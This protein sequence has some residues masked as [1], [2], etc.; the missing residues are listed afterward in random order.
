MHNLVKQKICLYIFMVLMLIFIDCVISSVVFNKFFVTY[1]LLEI[2]VIMIIAAPLFLFKNNKFSIAYSSVI[3]GL[4]IV[5]MVI[6]LLLNYAS[7]DIFSIKYLFLFNE[8]AQVM[9][10]Q[11]VNAWYIILAIILVVIY[12]LF[13]V[14]IHRIF[15]HHILQNKQ[16]SYKYYP[17]ALSIMVMAIA[18][19]AIFRAIGSSQVKKDFKDYDVYKGM[20][21]NEIIENS[22]VILK[23]GAIKNYGMLTY[24]FG[25]I[26]YTIPQGSDSKD[27]N[28]FFNEGKIVNKDITDDLSGVCSDKNVITIMIE[29][30]VDY[31]I[32][33]TLTPNLYRLKNDGVDFSKNYSKNKTNMSEMIGIIGSIAEV[34]TTKNYNTKATLPN[35]LKEEGYQTSYFHNNSGSFYDR[36]KVLETTGFENLYFKEDIDPKQT[37]NFISANYPLDSYF[38]SGLSASGM[39]RLEENMEDID[40][41]IEKIIPD[42]GKFFSFWTT[43]STHGPYNTSK[44]NM[45]YYTRL[46]YYQRII[47]AEHSG[48]WTNICADD[49]ENLQK[50][51]INLQAE[52]M[53][54]DLAVGTMLDRLESLD[55]LDDTLIV[56]YGDH[57][58]YYMSNGEKQLKYAMYNSDDAT[59]PELYSTTLIMYNTDLNSSYEAIYGNKTYDK[60]STP[61]V[62]VP[63]ILDLLGVE[64]NENYYVGKSAFMVNDEL[65]NIFYSHEL[66]AIFSDKVYSD[67]LKDYRFKA[68]GIDESYLERYDSYSMKM[69][70]R[71]K[72]FDR[73]Y[74]RKLYKLMK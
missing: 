73:F 13:V 1:P 39:N 12:V 36:R 37:H 55:I 71:I 35:I 10:M 70:T 68:E 4:F 63:T 65:E 42:T 5:I 38:M 61:Y 19:G 8:A 52:Y 16:K 7:G 54:L 60:F 67:N 62:I 48:L 45:D 72:L 17:I 9:S 53:D 26:T 74:Q 44:R 11:F 32:N 40:G 24:L 43:M 18:I 34:G 31:Y 6:S 59:N 25:E 50:Q 69:A 20:S 58:P 46:G 47:E 28:G 66:E 14:L 27:L 41:I 30:G 64:Y 3:F 51:V 33:E 29:T 56:L 15:N 21:G 22:S 49:N 2:S 23:R 57:E